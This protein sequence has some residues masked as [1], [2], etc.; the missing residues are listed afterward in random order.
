MEPLDV[1]HLSVPQS[2]AARVALLLK[3][4]PL[5]QLLHYVAIVAYRKAYTLKKALKPS[6][7]A[8][9][10]ANEE[11]TVSFSDSTIYNGDD[12]SFSDDSSDDDDDSEPILGLI[13]CYLFCTSHFPL[14][15][16][17]NILQMENPSWDS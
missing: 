14:K 11:D 2:A 7:A 15:I 12:F 17:T 13:Q 8:A 10:A 4:G 3:A 16:K 1:E 9:A 5:L 6:A